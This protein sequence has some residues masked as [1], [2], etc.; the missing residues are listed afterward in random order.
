MEG[1]ATSA[2]DHA[3]SILL[4]AAEMIKFR[5]ERKPLVFTL[6]GGETIE[7]AIRWFD[8]AAVHLV[9]PDRSEVTLMKH[10]IV[11]Y[12]AKS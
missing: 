9:A 10:A 2:R 11:L 6:V 4:S 7:G 8:D 12:R 5:D 3:P 1:A